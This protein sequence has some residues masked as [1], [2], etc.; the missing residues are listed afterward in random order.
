MPPDLHLSLQ[1]AALSILSFAGTRQE[2]KHAE[3]QDGGFAGEVIEK[4]LKH[5]SEVT[6]II[7][8]P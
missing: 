3:G 1:Q 5:G 8:N 4:A 7:T 2:R 6:K